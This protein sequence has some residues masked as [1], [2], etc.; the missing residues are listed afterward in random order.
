MKNENYSL[1]GQLYYLKK[2]STTFYH[3]CQV[4]TTY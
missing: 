2:A 3:K 1:L 4:P